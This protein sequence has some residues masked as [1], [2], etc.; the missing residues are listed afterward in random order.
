M[1]FQVSLAAAKDS[2]EAVERDFL[3]GLRTAQDQLAADRAAWRETLRTGIAPPA[4]RPPPSPLPAE[5]LSRMKTARSCSQATNAAIDATLRVER[6][7]L[8]A[9]NS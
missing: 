1:P 8:A 6:R 4:F 5:P 9:L 2:R 3:E 7:P